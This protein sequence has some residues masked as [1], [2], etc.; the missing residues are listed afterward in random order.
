[1]YIVLPGSVGTLGEL[2]L[3]W[4]HINIDFR[5]K[6]ESSKHLICWENPWKSFIGDAA[7]SLKLT[8]VDLENIHFVQTPAEAVDLNKRILS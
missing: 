7:F 5:V 4:N 2:A 1:M 3:A 8:A 6:K